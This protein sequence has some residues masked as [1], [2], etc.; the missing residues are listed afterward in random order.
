MMYL[1]LFKS[2]FT[3]DIN[4]YLNEKEVLKEN[5]RTV[6]YTIK[7]FDTLC[8]EQNVS[9]NILT[10]D[11]V[12]KFLVKDPNENET[13]LS[14]R[15]S[16]MRCFGRYLLRTGKEAYVLPIKTYKVGS[17]YIP[18]IYSK[19][20]IKQFLKVID[21]LE[22]K[23]KS[24]KKPIYMPI[25]YRLLYCCG[26]RIDE[27]LSLKIQDVNIDEKC[28]TIKDAKNHRDRLIPITSNL[29]DLLKK[30][31]ISYNYGKTSGEYFFT[32]S[33]NKKIT[34][35][36]FYDL[37]REYLWKAKIPHTGKGPRVHDFRF[38]FVVNCIHRW[39]LE[40][41]DLKVYL[42]LLQT[43]LGHVNISSTYYYY[44]MTLGLYPYL[45]KK[46]NIYNNNII[47]TLEEVGDENE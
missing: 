43:Y 34:I 19:E 22:K 18:H 3:E 14:H 17:K 20:E 44:Q 21:S 12:D 10:K 39:L 26:L 8:F 23:S 11:L 47:P 29:N 37:F 31:N 13:N 30:Y 6:Y 24:D 25:I 27:A 7:S 38:T 15:A 40:E 16:V 28:L 41:K 45:E 9:N 36:D 1:D 46:L 35:D 32:N 33:K 2:V 4:G 42:P 5:I